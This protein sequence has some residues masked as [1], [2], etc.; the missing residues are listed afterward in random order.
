M[1]RR[2]FAAVAVLGLVIAPNTSGAQ[3]EQGSIMID[4]YVGAPTA[5]VW[6]QQVVNLDGT[7]NFSTAGSPVSFGGRVEYM[8]ADNF[9]LGIDVNYAIAGY[10]YTDPQYLYDGTTGMYQSGEY[11]YTSKRLRAMLRFN[12]H[13]VQTDNLDMYL[14]VGAGYKNVKRTATWTTSS[15]TDDDATLTGSLLPVAFRVAMGGRYYFI[16][17]LGLN[18]EIGAGGGGIIQGGLAVKF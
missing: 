12:Y 8:L 2:L 3:V 14:G 9:G 13:F 18:F 11:K 17:N 6:W 10:K 5:N 16:P 7:E 1:K 4:P 15:G